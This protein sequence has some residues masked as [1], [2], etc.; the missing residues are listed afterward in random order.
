MK[1]IKK[2]KKHAKTTDVMM[3]WLFGVCLGFGCP[4]PCAPGVFARKVQD[5]DVVG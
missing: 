5:T 4:A 1:N 2:Y 3:F